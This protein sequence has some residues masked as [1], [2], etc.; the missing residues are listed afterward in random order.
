V[1]F[2]PVRHLFGMVERRAGTGASVGGICRQILAER[3]LFASFA[4][5]DA[6]AADMRLYSRYKSL[7]N[8]NKN[9]TVT[10][11][12]KKPK[13]D[14]GWYGRRAKIIVPQSKWRYAVSGSQGQAVWTGFPEKRERCWFASFFQPW[15]VFFTLARRPWHWR[16]T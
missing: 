15:Y 5:R 13:V 11:D 12:G 16:D 14:A 3:S 1:F 4:S 6:P 8:C 9:P 7:F 10:I 2:Q